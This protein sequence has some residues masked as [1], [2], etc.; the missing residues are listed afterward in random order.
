MAWWA[1]ILFGVA[2]LVA[3]MV[4]PGGLFALFFGIGALATGALVGAGLGG[5]TWLQWLFFAGLSVL[6]LGLLRRR[7][8]GK[9]DAG[10]P[11]DGIAGE[12]AVVL[13]EVPAGGVGQAEL[14][15]TP[16]EARSASG[17]PIARGTRCR[18]EKVVG[19]TLYLRPE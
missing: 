2:L 10:Q 12:A 15:G 4:A 7:W 6:L 14:R 11:V 13:A 19:L 3:E 16:W 8:R 18:V 17:E 5:P 1:W 9:L